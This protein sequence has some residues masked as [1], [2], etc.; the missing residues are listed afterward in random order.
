M[1]RLGRNVRYNVGDNVIDKVWQVE[2][3]CNVWH[4]VHGKVVRKNIWNKM[5]NAVR[6]RIWE[7]MDSELNDEIWQEG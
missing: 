6:N 5:W 3:H 4:N 1:I 7:Y 2:L